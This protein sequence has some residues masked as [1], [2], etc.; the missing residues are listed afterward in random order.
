M[1]QGVRTRRG[2]PGRSNACLRGGQRGLRPGLTHGTRAWLPRDRLWA[3][4][5]FPLRCGLFLRDIRV[6]GG[7]GMTPPQEAPLVFLSVCLSLC[8]SILGVLAAS[9]GR[10]GSLRAMR[11][12]LSQF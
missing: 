4:P 8:L 9:A 1:H 7:G 5:W 2:Q 6:G 12:L 3:L 10:P 11:G